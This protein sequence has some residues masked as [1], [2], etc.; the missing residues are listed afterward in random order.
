MNSLSWI[1]GTSWRFQ[2][3]FSACLGPRF[4]FFIFARAPSSWRA[5][6]ASI[7]THAKTKKSWERH[8][9]I[10][11]SAHPVMGAV[12]LGAGGGAAAP[13]RVPLW[14]CLW[15]PGVFLLVFF[16][17]C[18]AASL[19]LLLFRPPQSIFPLAS[20]VWSRVCIS[21]SSHT[22]RCIWPCWLSHIH[23]CVSAS[24]PNCHP[25]KNNAGTRSCPLL[26]RL[27]VYACMLFF[28]T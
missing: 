2:E 13:R 6:L 16:H 18:D 28:N 24:L 25:V 17:L 11:V 8:L 22:S 15:L 14:R 23:H 20:I 12:G 9:C 19:T 4:F 5:L 21:V 27:H 10:Q 1:S 26:Q 3:Y 7:F